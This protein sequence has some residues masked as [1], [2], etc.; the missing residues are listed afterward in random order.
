MAAGLF[1]GI[2]A[3]VLSFWEVAFASFALS[4]YFASDL[5]SIP[6]PALAERLRHL[7]TLQLVVTSWAVLGVLTVLGSLTYGIRTSL[8]YAII[9]LFWLVVWAW[10]RGDRS[11]LGQ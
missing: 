11:Q 6:S 4:I 7:S 2:T 3:L 8:L 1:L 5:L 9:P 10:W